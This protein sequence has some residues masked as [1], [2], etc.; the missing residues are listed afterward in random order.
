MSVR[1]TWDPPEGLSSQVLHRDG[2][3]LLYLTGTERMYDDPGGTDDSVYRVYGDPGFDTGP[4]QP[5]VNRAADLQTR[6]RFDHDWG[7]AD[8]RRYTNAG[9]NGIRVTIRVYREADWLA[10]RRTLALNVL[11]TSPD[12]RWPYPVFLEPGLNYVLHVQG[13]GYGPLVQTV[14]L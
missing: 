9:G 4:F 14:T 5:P 3:L 13:E 1:V 11:D 6:V 7:A 10:G 8:A 12:G 2:V